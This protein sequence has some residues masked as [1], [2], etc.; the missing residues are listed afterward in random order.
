MDSVADIRTPKQALARARKLFGKNAAVQFIPDAPTGEDRERWKAMSKEHRQEAAKHPG[1]MHPY[2]CY[3]CSIR[4]L[5]TVRGL[6]SYYL[7]LGTGDT[8]PDAFAAAE[9]N[10]RR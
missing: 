9:A 7:V 10:P 4:L 1:H 5:K 6:M 2:L 3:R 8:W